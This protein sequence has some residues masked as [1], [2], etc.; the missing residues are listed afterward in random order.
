MVELEKEVENNCNL[1]SLD[2]K[3]HLNLKTGTRQLY[4]EKS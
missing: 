3:L 2:I 1:S 4:P